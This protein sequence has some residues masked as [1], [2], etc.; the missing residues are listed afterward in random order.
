MPTWVGTSATARTPV[1]FSASS[2]V[3]HL[4]V[5]VRVSVATPAVG[6]AFAAADRAS[7]DQS[8]VALAWD[9]DPPFGAAGSGLLIAR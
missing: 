2:I 9:D 6:S 7:F 4:A 5:D 1:T 3:I 8:T